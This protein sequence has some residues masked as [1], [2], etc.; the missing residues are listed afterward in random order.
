MA[1]S[2]ARKPMTIS[3]EVKKTQAEIRDILQAIMEKLPQT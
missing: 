2:S 1:S 3:D